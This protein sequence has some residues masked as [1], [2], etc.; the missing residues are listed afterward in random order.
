MNKKEAIGKIN[1]IGKAG[2]VISTIAQVLLIL[3]LVVSIIGFVIVL[4]LP[5]DLFTFTIDPIGTA[6]INGV[7]LEGQGI[8][9]EMQNSFTNLDVN[10]NGINY[11][12]SNP[13]V[14]GNVINMDLNG[15]SI[16]FSPV[17]LIRI[18]TAAMVIVVFTLVLTAFIKKLCKSISTC[19]TPFSQDVIKSIEH[20]TWALIPWLIIGGSA[21]N[22]IQSAFTGNLNLGFSVDFT[23]IMVVLLLVALTYIF[24]YGAI[25]QTE[26]DE[27]L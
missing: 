24:K 14:D 3:G 8:D 21:K 17:Q 12:A 6:R 23:T 7:S 13:V 19:S 2:S 10:L 5:K 15:S 18:V 11:K 4:G 16:V 9:T 22:V 26:S 25:L 20:C 27:T 1:Q